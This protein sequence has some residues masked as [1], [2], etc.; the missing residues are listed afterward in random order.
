[1]EKDEKEE[2]EGAGEG[3]S[4]LLK[5]LL[6]ILPLNAIHIGWA[7]GFRV[8]RRRILLVLPPP[9]AFAFPSTTHHTHTHNT[10]SLYPAEGRG[11]SKEG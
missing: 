3:P 5:D 11:K 4:F 1:M 9:P 7:W 10:S 2:G 6:H 8:G